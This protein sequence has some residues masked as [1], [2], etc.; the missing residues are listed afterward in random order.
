M[1]VEP[2]IERP[3]VVRYRLRGQ[4]F[5]HGYLPNGRARSGAPIDPGESTIPGNRLSN[6]AGRC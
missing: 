6:D 2:V 5:L 3:T 4:S 1:R